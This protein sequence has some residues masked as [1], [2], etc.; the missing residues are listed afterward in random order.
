MTS[1]ALR[2]ILSASLL[3]AAPILAARRTADLDV[4]GATILCYHIVEWPQDPRMEITREAFHQQMR[5]LAMTEYTVVPLRDIYEYATGKRARLPKNPVAIT[6]DDGWRSTYTEVFPEMKRRHWPFTIFIYPKIIGQTAYALTWKQIKEMADAGVDIESHSYSHPFLTRRRH[7][8]LDGKQYAEWLQHELR[9]SKRVLQ[10]ET[11]R[12]VAFLAYPYGDYDHV[13]AQSVAK[14]GYDGALTCE[15]GRITRGS[16]PLRLKRVVIDK[17]MDF[18]AFRHYLGAQTMPLEEMSPQP[19]QLLDP[20]Q[21]V[22]ISARIPNYK[23]LDPKSV[24][25]A[26]LSM[27][28]SLP[29]SYDA[30]KGLISLVISEELTGRLQ[31]ALVW[32]TDT[33][34]G[35]RVEASWTFRLPEIIDPEFC[36]PIDPRILPTRPAQ[37]IAPATEA[38]AG[39]GG[40]GEGRLQFQRAPRQ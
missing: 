28:G 17:R 4:T 27:T 8:S 18:A 31:R 36:P 5:Y 40:S 37:S 24:G 34:S 13:V 6:I 25:I 1:K 35:R 10:H 14:A 23:T 39:R 19:G 29:Y 12:A 33:R 20:G 16:D 22:T 15:F 11:G 32:A 38:T 9:E 3:V 2:A 7:E 26:L 30:R 21:T